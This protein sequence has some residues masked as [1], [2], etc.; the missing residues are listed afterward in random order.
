MAGDLRDDAYNEVWEL[1][2][3]YGQLVSLINDPPKLMAML[4]KFA[5]V[6]DLLRT[7]L[8]T[9]TKLQ[10]F[11]EAAERRIM[12]N[13][14]QNAKDIVE[15]PQFNALDFITDVEHPELGMS[16]KYPGAPCYHISET[17]WRISRR[18]PLVGEH[19]RDIY[20]AELGLN[21]EQLLTLKTEGAI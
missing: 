5:H 11:D 8:M 13:P 2:S 17:P 14:V 15:S 18:A 21:R 16:L 1:I 9:K 7:F 4:E 19:N 12:I 6:S 10:I 3:D 20:E